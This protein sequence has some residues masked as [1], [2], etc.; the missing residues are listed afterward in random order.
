MKLLTLALG[1]ILTCALGISGRL[2]ADEFSLTQ[3]AEMDPAETVTIITESLENTASELE[4]KTIEIDV[5]QS[6]VIRK[7]ATARIN[8]KLKLI[9]SQEKCFVEHFIN[10]LKRAM[11]FDG[12]K[13]SRCYFNQAGKLDEVAIFCKNP[14]VMLEFLP[15]I[16]V[17]RTSAFTYRGNEGGLE[18]VDRFIERVLLAPPQARSID[19]LN[20]EIDGKGQVLVQRTA[21]DHHSGTI[22]DGKAE[23]NCYFGYVNNTLVFL[24]RD[25]V[26]Q[27][28]IDDGESKR[29]Q[30]SNIK[31]E[32]EYQSFSGYL[33]PSSWR[34]VVQLSILNMDESPRGK[35]TI[36]QDLSYKITQFKIHDTFPT[37]YLKPPV[38]ATTKVVDNCTAKVERAIAQTIEENAG[39]RKWWPLA[40]GATCLLLAGTVWIWKRRRP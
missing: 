15:F 13:T 33:L 27:A 22:I 2:L 16:Q 20:E 40:A 18:N 9:T 35:P 38:I 28:L 32:V 5:Q 10:D 21:K 7:P 3:L 29:L 19:W 14:S 26:S 39:W 31:H 23:T 34:H 24:G 8:N 30:R 1:A 12:K 6:G 4:G 17:G 25:S 37:E 11:I 36:V